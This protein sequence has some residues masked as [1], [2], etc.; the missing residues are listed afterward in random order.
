MLLKDKVVVIYGAGGA[1]GGAVARAF[2]D[3]GAEL[4]L[5]G[6]T[7]APVEVVAKDIL[8][9]DG[10]AEAAEVDTLDEQLGELAVLEDRDAGL[11]RVG[12]DDDLLF[13]VA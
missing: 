2:G 7:F 13:H 1:I 6:R 4:F 9:G 5:T 10:S 8:A 11:V 12:V 3:E